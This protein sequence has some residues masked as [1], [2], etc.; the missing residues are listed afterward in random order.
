MTCSLMHRGSR[1]GFTLIEIILVVVIIMTLMAV[2]GPKLTGQG[3]K[4]KIN[5]TKIQI[6]SLKQSLQN[7]ETQMSRFPTTQEGLQ[8]LITKPGSIDKDEWPGQLLEK[9]PK[10]GFGSEFK[11]TFPSEHGMDYDIVSPGPDKKLG[12]PDDIAN[13]NMDGGSSDKT[14]TAAHL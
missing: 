10:D 9:M 12:T 11:Y 4:Q 14:E 13:Y 8:A 6:N 3:K 1:R 5:I 7:F 2:V